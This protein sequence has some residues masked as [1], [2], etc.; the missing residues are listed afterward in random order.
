M[1]GCG[2]RFAFVADMNN[3]GHYTISDLWLQIKWLFFAPG[4]GTICFIAETPRLAR[5]F[6][7]THDSYGN[8]FSGVASAMAWPW[9]AMF[10]YIAIMAAFRR[11]PF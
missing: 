7:V 2:G 4:D 8:W 5:F 11:E 6:E 10:A 9:I 3:D 1:K